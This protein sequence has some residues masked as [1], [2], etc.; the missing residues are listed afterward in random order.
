L[1]DNNRYCSNAK[2]KISM[3][4]SFGSKKESFLPYTPLDF[5]SVQK[6]ANDFADLIVSKHDELSK[7]LLIY[8]SHEVVEDETE[9]TLDL[10]R[11]LDENKEYFKY[12]VGE[13]TTF[14]P[15]NQVLYA[16]SCFVVVPSLMA[17]EV[18]FRIPHSMKHFF[19]QLL[20]VLEIQK[21]F[22]GSPLLV[23]A[24][25][26]SYFDPLIV[27]GVLPLFYK[28]RPVYFFSKDEL[29]LENSLSQQCV[30]APKRQA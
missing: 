13:V 20:D 21:N 22:P 27:A 1:Y 15:R 11:N 16:F 12:R 9:R 6:K 29:F 5:K 7:I 8:E 10:L 17:S 18:H 24:N 2:E 3:I 19:Q 28:Y 25:H 4:F 23:V 14:L 30:N 26:K